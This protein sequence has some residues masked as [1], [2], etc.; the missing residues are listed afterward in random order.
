MSEQFGTRMRVDFTAPLKTL[1]PLH[2]G[3]GL[4]AQH[5]SVLG[6]DG[7]EKPQ[8]ALLQRDDKKF[9]LI[10]STSIKGMLRRLAEEIWGKDAGEVKAL[11]GEISHTAAQTGSQGLLTVFMAQRS[12][13]VPCASAM[14]YFIKDDPGVFVA[15]RTAIDPVSGT[16]ADNKL[17]F[18]EM[19]A[20][21][22]L[23]TL[24]CRLDTYRQRK[25]SLPPETLIEAVLRILSALS[26]H[27][28]VAVGKGQADGL[29]RL[30]LQ[31]DDLQVNQFLINDDGDFTSKPLSVKF[32]QPTDR[33]VVSRVTLCLFC[34]G[35][36]VIIDSSHDRRKVQDSTDN[37]PHIRS[38][39]QNDKLPLILGTS[40]S[41]ALR[42]RALWLDRLALLNNGND[43]A[44]IE[45]GSG[46]VERLFGSLDQR[47][48]ISIADLTVEEASP[49]QQTSVKLDRFSAAPIDGALFSTQGFAGVR[50]SVT[51]TLENRGGDNNERVEN[52]DTFKR[53]I[54][55]LCAEGLELGHG[56]NKGFGW[57]TVKMIGSIE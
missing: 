22:S 14:P 18:Q 16:A 10:P 38:Q 28:G 44:S 32:P 45:S 39:R 20:P 26:H 36:F 57:F 52:E 42:A 49:M 1:S 5:P 53:L 48:L 27:H 19:V 2:V 31:K 46:V 3:T 35:P 33:D 55:D 7:G 37:V 56:S 17:F 6:K 13:A 9:P 40:L 29:G 12:G 43:S 50:L 21:G 41:G 30:Q 34:E 15:A 8:V 47:S 23:F 25:D 51:L 11:F 24:R 54:Q 4:F